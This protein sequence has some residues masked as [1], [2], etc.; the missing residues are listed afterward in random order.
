MKLIIS[1]NGTAAVRVSADDVIPKLGFMARDII[2]FVANAYKFFVRPTIPPNIA[3]FALQNLIFQSGELVSGDNKWPIVQLVIGPNSEIITATTTEMADVIL[4]DYMARLDSAF[5]FRF[6]AASKERIYQSNVVVEFDGAFGEKLETFKKI[7]A[8]LNRAT[9][10][11]QQFKLKRLAFGYGDIQSQINSV[12]DLAQCD[13]VI[14]HRNG[15]DYSRNR[16]F[17]S[18]PLPTDAHVK[19]LEEIERALG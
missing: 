12:E 13:F 14:D 2:E 17:S 1:T 4:D 19:V 11:T 3:P 18:A 7:E 10:R 9:A 6:A 15:E 5:G 16:Y 8:I